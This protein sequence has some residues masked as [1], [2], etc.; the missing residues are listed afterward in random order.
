MAVV[1]L[2]LPS[3]RCAAAEV[4]APSLFHSYIL[5]YKS[6]VA[7][8]QETMAYTTLKNIVQVLERF[9]AGHNGAYPADEREIA[10]SYPA[11]AGG[12]YDGKTLKG[13]RYTVA[14]HREG[15]T[16]RAQPL[17]C[18]VTGMKTFNAAQRAPLYEEPCEDEKGET[19]EIAQAGTVGPEKSGGISREPQ[20]A[21]EETP[22]EPLQGQSSY[23]SQTYHYRIEAP[24]NWTIIPRKDFKKLTEVSLDPDAELL[25]IRKDGK[26]WAVLTA[27]QA[28][29][30]FDLKGAQDR[31]V[32]YLKASSVEISEQKLDFSYGDGGFE[33]S[34]VQPVEGSS[35]TYLML[36]ALYRDI[37][38]QSLV[39]ALTE[40]V[41]EV[42]GEFRD[43]FR[44]IQIE[45]APYQKVESAATD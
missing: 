7:K 6:T 2:V 43:I 11:E 20:E 8:M 42:F 10:S 19:L 30:P 24:E 23:T 18:G 16:L 27:V 29:A 1:L 37:G 35:V 34:W 21:P 44:I 12:T 40:D 15:Y 22:E 17:H 26:G 25:L 33:L 13:Y 41:D 36:F 32:E 14:V 3:V 38:I 4:D 28:G 39:W 5:Q 45:D 31:T 9:A